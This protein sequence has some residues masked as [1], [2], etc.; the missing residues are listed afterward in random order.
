MR[1]MAINNA[2]LTNIR[3]SGSMLATNAGSRN[4]NITFQGRVQKMYSFLWDLQ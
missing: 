3:K 2:G 1:I 4:T